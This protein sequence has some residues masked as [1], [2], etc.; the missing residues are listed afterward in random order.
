MP[1]P[2]YIPIPRTR[3]KCPYSGLSRSGIYNLIRPTKANGYR[4]V[5]D[6]TMVR[7]RG[8]NRGSRRV[9][10]RSLMQYLQAGVIPVERLRLS[11]FWSE[12]RSSNHNDG[13]NPPPAEL[14]PPLYDDLTDDAV[15]FI[16][17]IR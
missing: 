17:D 15:F 5:V 13:H 16:R 14:P 12:F 10:Y 4:P 8:K 9:S 6:S 1:E 11:R 2:E 3:T 7:L